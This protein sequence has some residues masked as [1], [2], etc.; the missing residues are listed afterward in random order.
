[1][2]SIIVIENVRRWPLDLQGAEVVAARDYLVSQGI[3]SRRISAQGYG[4]EK[5]LNHCVNGVLCTRD[6][7]MINQRMEVKVLSF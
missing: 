6:D 1:M 3:E 4:E 7:H 5:P 2:K